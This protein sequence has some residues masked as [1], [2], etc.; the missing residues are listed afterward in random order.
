M[1]PVA[2]SCIGLSLLLV[3]LT[4]VTYRKIKQRRLVGTA[5]YGLQTFLVLALLAGGLLILSNLNTYQRLSFEENIVEVVI[6]RITTQ[7]FELQLVYAEAAIRSDVKQI[8]ILSG[9]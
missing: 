6:K 8:Y 1:N 9:D 5:L 3:V 2:Y 7:K 4:V